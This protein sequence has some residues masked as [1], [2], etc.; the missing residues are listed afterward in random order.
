MVLRNYNLPPASIIL[1]EE[2]IYF[3]SIKCKAKEAKIGP[4]WLEFTDLVAADDEPTF[5]SPMVIPINRL[6]SVYHSSYKTFRIEYFIHADTTWSQYIEMSPTTRFNPYGDDHGLRKY[7]IVR[8]K[9][10]HQMNKTVMEEIAK[11]HRVEFSRCDPRLASAIWN[12]RESVRRGITGGANSEATVSRQPPSAESVPLSGT[13]NHATSSSQTENVAEL[14]SESVPANVNENRTNGTSNNG[15]QVD[16]NNC[17]LL[18]KVAIQFRAQRLLQ[19]VVEFV[20]DIPIDFSWP[21]ALIGDRDE[22]I[23][24][25]AIVRRP[26]ATLPRAQTAARRR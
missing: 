4:H 8:A 21:Q 16:S 22:Y 6:R 23:R 2:Y 12:S 10:L 3:G 25:R 26:R 9:T 5:K 1:D 15:V 14:D 19:E 7:I 11:N 24:N 18:Y 20:A 13:I 17:V